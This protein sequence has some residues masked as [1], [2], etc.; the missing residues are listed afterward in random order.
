MR[1]IMR[2][3]IFVVMGLSC[4]LLFQRGTL[5]AAQY[6]VLV[7]MSYEEDFLWCQEIKSGIDSI[8]GVQN[9]VRYFYMDTKTH[10]E[11]GTQKAQEAYAVYQEFQPDGV[12]AVDD[13]AQSLFVVPYL[14]DKVTTPVMFTGV[15]AEPEKYGYPASNVSGIVEREHF[16]ESFVL[17]QRLVPTAKTFAI[18]LPNDSTGKGILAQIENEND[19]YPLALTA[20]KIANTYE[21]L[22]E[23]VEALTPTTDVLFYITFEGLP[24]RHGEAMLDE[25]ILPAVAEK[26]GKPILTDAR[27]RIMLGALCAVIKTEKELGT[28]ASQMLLNAMQGT[29]VSEI[30]IA[31]NQFGRRIINVT[32]IK[33]LGITPPPDVL[34]GA[35][36]VTTQP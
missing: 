21:E 16:K 2:G 10:P 13:N 29:P 24:N 12:I 27:F 34:R 31:Q 26:F 5:E 8:L 36:L 1:K 25:A 33:A 18:V 35:E 17:A 7:V 4:M 32:V 22:L 30:P 6:K 28:T 14:K 3:F 9:E 19:Q 20:A 23:I 15:N 11:G